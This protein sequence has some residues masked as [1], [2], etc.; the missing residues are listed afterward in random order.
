MNKRMPTIQINNQLRTNDEVLDLLPQLK[1][2]AV[3]HL[4]DGCPAYA[5]FRRQNCPRP[6]SLK[7]LRSE[8]RRCCL[9]LRWQLLA[10]LPTKL[11]GQLG[12]T[13]LHQL[14]NVL[15]YGVL[16]KIV[17]SFVFL[18]HSDAEAWQRK[19]RQ[20]LYDGRSAN[21]NQKANGERE[22]VLRAIVSKIDVWYRIPNPNRRPAPNYEMMG[23][24]WAWPRT[25][26]QC[27]GC[28]AAK[29]RWERLQERITQ[30][31][32]KGTLADKETLTLVS[33]G[34]LMKK[35]GRLWEAET[36]FQRA[37]EVREQPFQERREYNVVAAIL[38]QQ[39]RK[40]PVWRKQRQKRKF[41]GRGKQ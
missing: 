38:K 19:F 3:F 11:P 41:T 37:L 29:R 21:V 9:K 6:K 20:Y 34:E 4:L 23:S 24:A 39:R 25:N 26:C 22:A 35:R 32:T 28:R 8:L 18:H 33:L 13:A 12:T 1:K 7:K 27:H 31:I 14:R 5:K 17:N 36:L 30:R 16:G 15:P 10:Q 40:K 2:C